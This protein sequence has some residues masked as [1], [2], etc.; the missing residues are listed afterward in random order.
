MNS[1]NDKEGSGHVKAAII[2][3]VFA[4]LAAIVGESFLIPN[5]FALVMVGLQ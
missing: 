5:T 1:Q 3:G 4:L 2:G